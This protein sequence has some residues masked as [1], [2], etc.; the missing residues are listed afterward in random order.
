MRSILVRLI[1]AVALGLCG[2]SLALAAGPADKDYKA[3]QQLFELRL[4]TQAVDE[5][6]KFVTTY[7][8]DARVAMATFM[9]GRA[10]QRQQKYDKALEAYTQVIA[11]AV[12]PDQAKLRA[13]TYYYMAECSL[14]QKDY[15]KAAKSYRLCLGTATADKDL[16]LR[17]QYWLAECLFQ[18]NKFPDAVVE[19][20]RVVELAPDHALAPWALYSIGDIELRRNNHS[21]AIAALEKVTTQYKDSEVAGEATLTLAFAYVGRARSGA[22]TKANDYR[23]A[24]ELFT[25]VIESKKSTPTAVQKAAVALGHA[26]FDVKDYAK[27]A[28]AYAKA[29]ETQDGATQSATETRLWRG[30][31]LYNG[32]KFD[33][34]LAEYARVAGSKYADLA[35]LGQY[36]SGNAWFQVAT[37][38]KEQRAYTE[39]I[40]AFQRFL[41]APGAKQDATITRATLLMGFCQEDLAGLGAAD[42]RDKA[43]ATF[44]EIVAKW[45]ASREAGEANSGIA[46][47]TQ[48]M[49][50]DELKSL[51][52]QLPPQAISAVALQLARQEFLAGRY[53]AAMDAAKKVVDSN[54]AVEITA[55]ATYLIAAS[56]HKLGATNDA[57]ASYKTALAK[58]PDTELTPLIQ[59]GLTQ[60]YLDARN[61]T[62][63]LTSAQ[64]LAASKRVSGKEMAEA[65]MFLAEAYL[66]NG[67]N[68]DALAAYRRVAT[69]FPDSELAPNAMLGQAWVNET[70]KNRD[71][72]ITG[73]G[74]LI[75]KYPNSTLKDDAAFHLG[76]NYAEKKDFDNAIK[77]YAMVPPAHRLADQAAY[78]IAWAYRDQG[79]DKEANAQ[80]AKVA[81]A[82]P[83][84]PLAC[85]SLYRIGEYWLAQT[86]Y[87]DAMLYFGRAN[88]L[89]PA[90]KLAPLVCYKLGVCAFFAA[91]YQ[92]AANAFGKVTANYPTSEYV[93]ES[94]FWKG[95]SLEKLG[96]LAPARDAY[97]AYLK[98]F[99]RM[100]LVLDAALGSGRTGL[101][102][103]QYAV[104]R[105]DLQKALSLCDEV[106]QGTNLAL[107]ERS[108][109]VA[110]EAQFYLGQ[111]YFDEKKYDQAFKEFAA[112]DG[113][114]YEPWGSRAL[115]ALAKCG[116]LTNKM[117][118]AA[119]T[120]KKLLT[121]YPDSEAAKSASDVAKEFNI[122]LP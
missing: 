119:Y 88:D 105:T 60:A 16:T 46:R 14:A 50:A 72:A 37:K 21:Q 115:L 68:A 20:K 17:A 39:A 91:H 122:P 43:I 7:P 85:D 57:I 2:A 87:T 121:N 116:A 45:P 70:L 12:A 26:Y 19:Y 33:D 98:G 96:Q 113:Y 90:D 69:E 58:A 35:L 56:Q 8:T 112:V 92:E 77:Y 97:Q 18:L 62:E 13:E 53:Q 55:Q 59:R 84:S 41:K 52:G 3:A 48:T 75:A 5:L 47:L 29:L 31:A 95:Q 6:T 120:L 61:Y 114:G 76:Y 107:K 22:D 9:I 34:A 89:N 66:N 15:E 28:D 67:K 11:K 10:Q 1:L 40:N 106:D 101:L 42:M 81:D 111:S 103:K 51:V 4:D 108:K 94:F 27:A 100:N 54:P 36:W 86:Q 99:P 74:D 117:D 32:G 23:R 49:T 79:K 44:R 65:L 118:S 102:L 63:A 71:Q 80:F 93:A 25:A 104:A 83:K 82:F 73:Y 109:N 78:A 30:H 24:T 64:A 110:P 38:S